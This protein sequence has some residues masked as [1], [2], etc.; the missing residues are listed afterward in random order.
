MGRRGIRQVS[1][2]PLVLCLILLVGAAPGPAAAKP[3]HSAKHGKC[4]AK[5]AHSRKG[6]KRHGHKQRCAKGPVY[7]GHFVTQQNSFTFSQAPMW[8]PDGKRVVWY[9]PIDGDNQVVTSKLDGSDQ[10][11]VTCGQPG[12]NQVAQY[13]PQG[14]V[15]LFHSWREK[16]AFKVGSPGFG[17]IGSEVYVTN[18]D[19]SGHPV[20]LTQ[21]SPATDEGDTTGEGED[22]YHA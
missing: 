19:G 22:N 2:A 7:S 13:R 4:Q 21:A 10:Q 5:N 17:G 9:K 14:D 11:C 6:R 15:I 8:S 12:P 20:N 18:A 1:A 3:R 16:N